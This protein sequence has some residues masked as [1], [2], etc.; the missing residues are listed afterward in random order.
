MSESESLAASHPTVKLIQ[1][2][3]LNH[4]PPEDYN[5]RKLIASVLSREDYLSVLE[6]STKPDELGYLRQK[7]YT[8]F[9][10]Q[11]FVSR[12]KYTASMRNQSIVRVGNSYV[13][14]RGDVPDFALNRIVEAQQDDFHFLTV[15]SNR[16]LPVKKIQMIRL[17]PVVVAWKR[18]PDIRYHTFR[19][20]KMHGDTWGVVI[21]VWDM[22]TEI[23]L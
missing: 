22:D 14:Y 16:P 1:A 13:L 17:D 10:G 4:D 20:W 7:G 23:E 2:T 21:A 15:H 12:F 11:Q 5:H 8:W 6:A 19:G 18:N 3:A 9:V